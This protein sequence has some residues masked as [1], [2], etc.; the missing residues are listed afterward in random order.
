MSII[1]SYVLLSFCDKRLVNGGTFHFFEAIVGNTLQCCTLLFPYLWQW[2]FT[3]SF[4]F[5]PP[6]PPRT[7][8]PPLNTA[9]NSM[10]PS[11]SPSH[12]S[13]YTPVWRKV[14]NC[15]TSMSLDEAFE[16]LEFGRMSQSSLSC[17][18]TSMVRFKAF[19]QNEGLPTIDN[20]YLQKVCQP[21]VVF[22]KVRIEDHMALRTEFHMIFWTKKRKSPVFRTI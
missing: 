14:W 19:H 18:S 9:K 1:W 6:H 8:R 12:D 20:F 16:L 4:R 5:G 7:H 10:E 3:G 11:R 13:L 22:C 17:R 21:A 15:K 2:T